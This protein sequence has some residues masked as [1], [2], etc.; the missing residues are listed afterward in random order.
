M[1][2]LRSRLARALIQVL[3]AL[4]LFAQ[5]AALTHAV[6]HS[7]AGQAAQQDDAHAYEHEPAPA[8]LAGLC[9]YD[10]AFGLVLGG[11][12]ATVAV[13]L[14]NAPVTQAALPPPDAFSP[15]D[16]LTPRSRGPPILL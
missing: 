13:A 14:P 16:A 7:A 12:C 15:V 1:M 9:A 4:V 2:P 8:R 3:C 10:A 11:A 5:Q 6:W